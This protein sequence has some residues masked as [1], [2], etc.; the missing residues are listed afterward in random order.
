MRKLLLFVVGALLGLAFGSMVMLFLAPAPGKQVRSG[1]KSRYQRAKDAAQAASDAKR[2]ELEAELARMTGV[3]LNSV[4]AE[5]EKK[6]GI[7]SSSN[8]TT[9]R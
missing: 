9:R 4:D 3:R 8:A 7:R 5:L 1:A 6:L 2:R